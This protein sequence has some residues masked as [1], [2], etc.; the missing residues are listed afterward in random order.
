MSKLTMNLGTEFQSR[1]EGIDA[2]ILRAESTL[3]LVY[4][5]VGSV[6]GLIEIA[7]SAKGLHAV[8]KNSNQG[9]SG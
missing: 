4:R 2:V 6:T 1:C 7:V 5:R 3:G 9:G 8:A